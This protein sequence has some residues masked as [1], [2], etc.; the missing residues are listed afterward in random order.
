MNIKKI[1]ICLF[2]TLSLVFIAETGS[3]ATGCREDGGPPYVR[4]LRKPFEAIEEPD[5][6]AL[7][8]CAEAIAMLSNLSI[9]IS[10]ITINLGAIINAIISNA[11][12]AVC[13]YVNGQLNSQL[14]V[15]RGAFNE[16]N[17]TIHD[18]K[19]QRDIALNSSGEGANIIIN[20]IGAG[21]DGETKIDLNQ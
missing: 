15:V 14:D 2:T 7:E 8:K 17:S 13:S 1:A 11:L 16:V 5:S 6:T 9:G 20:S 19:S 12:S 3:A 18:L 21:I 4:Y 10:L